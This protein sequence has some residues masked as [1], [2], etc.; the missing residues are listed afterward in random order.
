MLNDLSMYFAA[1]STSFYWLYDNYRYWIYRFNFES[2]QLC[3]LT[4]DNDESF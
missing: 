1:A 3:N 2:D 4:L